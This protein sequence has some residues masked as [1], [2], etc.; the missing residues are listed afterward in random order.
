MKKNQALADQ[1]RREQ[2]RQLNIFIFSGKTGS[3][4]QGRRRW[5]VE[6]GRGGGGGRGM[7]TLITVVN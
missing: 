7:G 6:M 3:R 4:I 5:E 2:A 1:R